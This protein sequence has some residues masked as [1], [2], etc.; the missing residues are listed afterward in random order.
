VLPM[1][2]L[3]TMILAADGRLGPR[4]MSSSYDAYSELSDKAKLIA[5]ARML[6]VAVPTTYVAAN[7][8]E[9]EDAISHLQPPIVI[10]PAKS[11]YWHSGRVHSTQVSV[12][13]TQADAARLL[14]ASD[15]LGRIPALLQEFIPG[16]GAG[17]FALFCKGEP[18]AWFAHKRVREKPPQGG[19]SVLCESTPLDELLVRQ[20]ADILRSVTWSGPAM[21][22]FKVSWDGK[23][24]LME[25]NAR[26]WGSLQLAIDCGIDFPW[27]LYRCVNG[28]QMET[29]E[30]YV[31]GRRL[32]WLLGDVDST[33]IQLR[34][35]GRQYSA[36]Q[37]VHATLDLI[38]ATFH[39]KVRAEILRWGDPVP[40]L[41]EFRQW[42]IA[43][44]RRRA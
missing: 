36:A 15:W 13:M 17:V 19:V 39:P 23:P 22:E 24:Y 27:L 44:A 34:D 9:A 6:G 12:A 10:K 32:H 30:K 35:Q 2:D 29:T 16:H 14:A 40:A 4:L 8:T 5:R 11:R 28:E 20:C 31:V 43:L 3:S 33:L 25:A 21:L 18:I 26:F 41:I 37:K 7:L 1:T 42:L 38:F